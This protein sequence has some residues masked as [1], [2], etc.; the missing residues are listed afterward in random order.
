V[1]GEARAEGGDVPTE[2]VTVSSGQPPQSKPEPET[3]RESRSRLMDESAIA[4]ATRPK[5]D[6]R[7]KPKLRPAKEIF[8]PTKTA[9]DVPD[10]THRW[11][12]TVGERQAFEEERFEQRAYIAKWKKDDERTA[13]KIA[14]E[15]KSLE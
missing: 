12:P 14:A 8:L 9:D 4:R 6:E 2:A 1:E 5:D 15:R 3:Q 7:S 13:A 10:M 11:A